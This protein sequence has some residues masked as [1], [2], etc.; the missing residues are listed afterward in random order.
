MHPFQLAFL[1]FLALGTLVRLWLSMRQLKAMRERRNERPESF[2]TA[3][4][5]EEHQKASDYTAAGTKVGLL[6]IVVDSLLLVGWTVGGGLQFVDSWVTS[7]GMGPLLTGVASILVALFVMHMLSLPFSLYRTFGVEARFGFNKTTPGLFFGDMIKGMIVA[8]VLAVPLLAAILWIMNAAGTYWWLYAWVV[9]VAF[10]LAITWAY[11]AFIAPLFN[12]F[13]ELSD[14]SLIQR[15]EQLL[16][17]CGFKSKGI[18]VMDGSRRSTHGNAY[19]TGVGNNKRIVF[20]DTLIDSL[21]PIE[22]EAVLAHELGHFKKKHIR[23]RLIWGFV[24]GLI[25]LAILGFMK[26]QTWFYSALG[27]STP[28]SHMA[29]LLFLMV[30]PVFTF[31]LTPISSYFSRKHEFEA[32]EYAFEQSDANALITALGKLYKENSSTLVPDEIHSQFYDSHPPGPVRVA[33]L[34]KLLNA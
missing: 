24:S 23:S 34:Q 14:D 2:D 18:Y 20:F 30:I 7:F 4:T 1:F 29:L 19:F 10:S 13:S 9:W 3:V 5:I 11:P 26:E 28:S 22:I 8:L 6:D 17:R 25:G 32:D 31:F 21:E 15:I 27:I 33:Y 12:K 16:Q